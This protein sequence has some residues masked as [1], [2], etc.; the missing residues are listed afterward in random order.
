MDLVINDDNLQINEVQEINTKVRA[1]LVDDNNKILI[2]NY[3]HVILLPG[4]KVD[5]GE[6]VS[7]AITRE[8]TEELG[9]NYNSDELEFFRTLNYYQK[10]YPKRDGTFQNRLIKTHYFIGKYKD[11]KSNLQKLTEKEIKDKF[12]LELV[13]IDDLENMILNNENNNPRNRYFQ[14]EL[15][16]ILASYK[17]IKQNISVKKLELK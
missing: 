13:L 6:T 11:V 5:E 10:N 14:T 3:G 8:L 16:T 9:Q 1:I 4:G 2:A 17:N 7:G 12:T 15:L